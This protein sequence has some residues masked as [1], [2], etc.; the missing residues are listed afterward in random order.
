LYF[1]HNSNSFLK[2]K[3]ARKFSISDETYLPTIGG[4]EFWVK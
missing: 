4:A 2:L 1:L 3:L